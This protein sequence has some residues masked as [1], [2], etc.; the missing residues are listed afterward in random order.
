MPQFES[1]NDSPHDALL[2]SESED[3]SPYDPRLC[4]TLDAETID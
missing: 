4:P 3:G 1:D 2:K